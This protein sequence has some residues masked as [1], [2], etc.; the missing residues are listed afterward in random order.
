MWVEHCPFIQP[1]SRS[2]EVSLIYCAY[3][4][5]SAAEGSSKH[6]WKDVCTDSSAVTGLCQAGCSK[7]AWTVAHPG[8][9]SKPFIIMLSSLQKTI[10]PIY[11]GTQDYVSL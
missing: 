2:K 6:V 1:N 3:H 9:V 5:W 4:P 11:M 8:L 10:S 7:I